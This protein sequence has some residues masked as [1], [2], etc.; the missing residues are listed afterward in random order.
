MSSPFKR[1]H[2]VGIAV[3]DIEA[4]S[5]QFSRMFGV[6]KA[7]IEHDPSESGGGAYFCG[8]KV[9]PDVFELM[10]ED[11]DGPIARFLERRGEGIYCIFMEVTNLDEAIETMSAEG[12]A[13][14]S[15]EPIVLSD[16]T[17]YGKKYSSVR[18]TWTHPKTTH[19]VMIELQEFNV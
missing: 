12:V 5:E 11:G 8:L 10:N 18:L 14:T 3:N 4:A 9:G 13:F 19:G 7:P 16:A 17:Y 1:I 2:Q 6:K 15:D